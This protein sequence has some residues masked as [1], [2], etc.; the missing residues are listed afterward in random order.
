MGSEINDEEVQNES[1]YCY[2]SQSRVSAE[3]T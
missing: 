2:Q 1:T 3:A